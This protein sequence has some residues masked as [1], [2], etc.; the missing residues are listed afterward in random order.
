MINQNQMPDPKELEDALQRAAGYK[1]VNCQELVGRALRQVAEDRKTL[2]AAFRAMKEENERIDR[3]EKKHHDEALVQMTA[4]QLAEA[5]L[6]F[7]KQESWDKI[8]SALL[9]AE[10]ARAEKAEAALSTAQQ[11]LDLSR[12][13]C[14]ALAGELAEAKREAEGLRLN[15]Q[16]LAEQLTEAKKE[17]T[18]KFNEGYDRG[19]NQVKDLKDAAEAR[20]LVLV[21]ALKNIADRVN[22]EGEDSQAC[23]SDIGYLVRKALSQSPEAE[24]WLSAQIEKATGPL[25]EALTKY[26]K[27][28]NDAGMLCSFLTHSKHKCDCGFAETKA[29][30]TPAPDQEDKP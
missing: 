8:K 23:V 16:E 11:A 28:R 30:L 22:N 21:E 19:F 15:G 5:E 13:N 29:A 20:N 14:N 6:A 3:L 18:R 9:E 12:S 1:A 27:H 10:R 24:S 4:R 17:A 7:Y 25:K 26:G 2:A